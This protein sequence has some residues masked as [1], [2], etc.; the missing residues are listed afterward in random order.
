[1]SLYQGKVRLGGVP[2]PFVSRATALKHANYLNVEQR[3]ATANPAG[4]SAIPT[5]WTPAKVSRKGGQIQIRMGGG[6]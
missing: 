1:V 3:H 5:K 6:R 4:P 2:E